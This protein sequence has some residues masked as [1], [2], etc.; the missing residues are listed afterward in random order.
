MGGLRKSGGL[1]RKKTYEAGEEAVPVAHAA[2][3]QHFFIF[4]ATALC[5]FGGCLLW[6]RM[7][8][9]SRTPC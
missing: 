8:S 9:V 3:H 5:Y 2:R 1:A 6:E 7:E 4:F